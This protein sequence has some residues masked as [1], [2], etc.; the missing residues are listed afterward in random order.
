VT[1]NAEKLTKTGAKAVGVGLDKAGSFIHGLF[2]H[3]DQD[4]NQNK[5]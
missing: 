3:K 4:Q 1:Q 5:N 2:N